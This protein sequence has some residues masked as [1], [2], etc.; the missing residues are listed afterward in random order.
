MERISLASCRRAG[1]FIAA[2]ELRAPW[3]P[4]VIEAI[5]MR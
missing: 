4:P 5:S 2:G 1:V 3:Q